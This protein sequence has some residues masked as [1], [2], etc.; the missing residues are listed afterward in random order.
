MLKGTHEKARLNWFY[1]QYLTTN[2]YEKSPSLPA[3]A[4]SAH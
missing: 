2:I 3:H 4:A 1:L